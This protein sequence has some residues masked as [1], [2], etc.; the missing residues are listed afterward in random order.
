[1]ICF[2][3]ENGVFFNT[4]LNLLGKQQLEMAIQNLQEQIKLQN[5]LQ[6]GI[7]PKAPFTLA[8]CK[9]ASWPFKD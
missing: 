1:L 2:Q 9:K 6:T 7:W 4:T 8:I 3:V 5:A